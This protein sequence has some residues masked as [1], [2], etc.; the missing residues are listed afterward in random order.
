MQKEGII[1]TKSVINE[2]EKRYKTG[3]V[4]GAKRQFFK[5]INEIDIIDQGKRRMRKTNN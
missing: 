1:N 4:N 2:I 3:D 5:K